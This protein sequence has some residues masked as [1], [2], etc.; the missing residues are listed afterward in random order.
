[1]SGEVLGERGFIDL[2][3]LYGACLDIADHSFYGIDDLCSPAVAQRDGQDHFIEMGGLLFGGANPV[4]S[5]LRK[6][7]V[8]SDGA[9]ANPLLD[10][11]LP[12]R[13]EVVLQESHK[14]ADFVS[15]AIPVLL[16]ERVD[17]QGPNAQFQTQ[18]DHFSDGIDAFTMA[19]DPR[20]T[21]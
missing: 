6:E 8:A 14:G 16:R 19:S 20:K 9:E 4:L 3:R 21:T 10:Q 7:I 17:R 5:G 15:W 2:V 13:G 11:T 12:F 18:G 1:M